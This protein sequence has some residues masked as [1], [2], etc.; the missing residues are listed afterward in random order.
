[1]NGETGDT[2]VCDRYTLTNNKQKMTRNSE[3]K[4][5]IRIAG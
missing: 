5:N 3:S 2:A 4:Q 1:M